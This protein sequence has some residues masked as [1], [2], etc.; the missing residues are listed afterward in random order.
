MVCATVS[1]RVEC[2]VEFVVVAAAVVVIV[3]DVLR[4][5]TAAGVATPS[6]GQPGFGGCVTPLCHRAAL[7]PSTP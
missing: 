2:I 7:F 5:I 1:G 6:I 4:N 3:G